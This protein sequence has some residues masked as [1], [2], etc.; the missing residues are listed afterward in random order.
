MEK[1][2]TSKKR[3]KETCSC[4]GPSSASRSRKKKKLVSEAFNRSGWRR[5]MR[6]RSRRS[7]R[8]SRPRQNAIS[9]LSSQRTSG[10]DCTD[11]M[12]SVTLSSPKPQCLQFI[13]THFHN[14]RIFLTS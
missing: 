7:R 13:I 12:S 9:T 2:R 6:I 4:L 5:A 3:K 10:F 1:K 8:E 14:G 11:S